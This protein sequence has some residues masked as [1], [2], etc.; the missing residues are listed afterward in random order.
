[1]YYRTVTVDAARPGQKLAELQVG[2]NSAFMLTVGGVPAEATSVRLVIADIADTPEEFKAVKVGGK[3]TVRINEGYFDAAGPLHYE[4]AMY[5]GDSLYFDGHGLIVVLDR[6]QETVP[7]ESYVTD[8]SFAK[9]TENS[10]IHVSAEDRKRWNAGLSGATG[11]TGP[12]GVD[13]LDG[14]TG[15][16]G[17]KGERGA[18]GADGATGPTGASGEDGFS[19][20][21][22][23]SRTV[24]GV[25]VT[26][27]RKGGAET[28]TLQDGNDGRDGADGPTG[29]TGEKGERGATGPTGAK[30]EPGQNGATGPTG[31]T[32]AKGKAG[33]AGAQGPTG[34]TGAKGETGEAFMIS[35]VYASKEDMDAGFAEDGVPVGGFAVIDTGSVEDTDTG[36]LYRKDATGYVFLTDLSGAQGIQGPQGATGPTGA[37]GET[38]APGDSP[39]VR[40]VKLAGGVQITV[41]TANGDD[42]QVVRDG[43]K[44]EAGDM[45]ATG[46]AGEKG[47][48]GPTGPKGESGA[49]GVTGPTGDMGATGPT[50]ARGATGVTG[51][52]GAQGATGERG[53]SGATGAKGETGDVGPTGPTGAKGDM[54]ATGPTGPQG[55]S[56]MASVVRTVGGVNLNGVAI[57]VEN[58]SGPT[59]T[60]TLYDGEDG[61]TGPTGPQ[62]PTGERGDSGAT[63]PAGPQGVTGPTGDMGATGPTGARGAAGVTGP[64]GAQG[65]T[66]ERGDSGATG[67]TGS[68]GEMGDAGPTGPMGPTGQAGERGATGASPAISLVQVAAGVQVNGVEYARDGLQIEFAYPSGP[69]YTGILYHGEDGDEGPTGPAGATG[70]TGID[71]VTGPTGPTGAVA[72]GDL[73]D[74]ERSALKEELRGATG[75]TGIVEGLRARIVETQLV[76][77]PAGCHL[78]FAG[79]LGKVQVLL[80]SRDGVCASFAV[81]VPSNAD[82]EVE[83]VK[84]STVDEDGAA[85][86]ETAFSFADADCRGRGFIVMEMPDGGFA[87]SPMDYFLGAEGASV[88]V[89]PVASVSWSNGRISEVYEAVLAEGRR[90]VLDETTPASSDENRL[91]VIYAPPRREAGAGVSQP[92]PRTLLFD[93]HGTRRVCLSDPVAF[94]AG[95]GIGGTFFTDVEAMETPS[96]SE[97]EYP[98]AIDCPFDD[99]MG[100]YYV[101]EGSWALVEQVPQF[102]ADDGSRWSRWALV[103]LGGDRALAK[104]QELSD[105]IVA[106]RTDVQTSLAKAVGKSAFNSLLEVSLSDTAT[107]QDVRIMVKKILDVLKGAA[108]CIALALSM[109]AFGLDDG[110]IWEK[111]P[112]TNTVKSVMEQFS[113]PP[114]FSTNNVELVGTIRTAMGAG[115]T[116]AVRSV[117]HTL[118]DYA[119]DAESEVCWR[120]VVSGGYIDYIAVTNIDLTLPENAAALEAAEAARRAK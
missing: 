66:G 41:E 7:R 55:I 17:E 51:P 27:V 5:V 21:I 49:A 11:P 92:P 109:P 86:Y 42:S 62:G 77:D 74:D 64:T 101:E 35:K 68:R 80:G 56:P 12:A 4:I 85:S 96:H 13:G 10:D 70:P 45:G 1:M 75:P 29:P 28:V 98:M 104:T 106:L 76:A 88:G 26:V 36:K 38:G 67:P 40:L 93:V 19:P 23:V 33:E 9:H 30:G 115:M 78:T 90:N 50:G 53:D 72:W 32:G 59:Y 20:D 99:D 113:P 105:T 100:C 87:V 37:K 83:L 18:D 31:P 116:N 112:P 44:G 65:A 120:R 16:T 8:A 81:S 111:V 46:P 24:G 54:G 118:A 57:T 69:T 82:T 84:V 48:V 102:A 14:P 22:S 15:P 61:E 43:E 58:A 117:A 2:R 95:D 110:I 91:Y 103:S 60:A 108:I 73:S 34:P 89:L 47:D 3:W 114:D 107:Q 94:D 39:K 97:T 25:S 63:G 6:V 71:G 119:W 52:T 79:S